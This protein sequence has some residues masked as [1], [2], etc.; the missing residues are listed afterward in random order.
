[1][2]LR[3]RYLFV[4]RQDGQTHW[5]TRDG[6]KG[7]HRAP[8]AVATVLRAL[9][10]ARVAVVLLLAVLVNSV[11]APQA[12]GAAQAAA[13]PVD[14]SVSAWGNNYYGQL[15]NGTTTT[16]TTPVPVSSLSGVTAIAG[17][18]FDSLALRS[19]GTVWAWGVNVYGEL[20]NGTTCDPS[21]GANC[22]STP[23]QVSG[24]RTGRQY[25]APPRSMA[26]VR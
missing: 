2:T 18:L 17:G 9:R 4:R 8:V 11:V 1:M 16:S 21:T 26:A 24:S 23:V 13:A 10:P 25:S 5:T 6:D 3:Q 14:G 7:R 15:G 12:L 22:S 20:G 19:D